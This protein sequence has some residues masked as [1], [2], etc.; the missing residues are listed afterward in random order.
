V[1]EFAATVTEIQ[2]RERTSEGQVW[3]MTIAPSDFQDGDRGLL[4]ATSRSGAVLEIP[5]TAQQ[6]AD[7]STW[8]LAA[9]PLLAGTAVMVVC[10]AKPDTLDLSA[11]TALKGL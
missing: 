5:V 11:R 2:E 4:R 6:N 7:G 3:Q 8:L 9:K 10:S 1:I